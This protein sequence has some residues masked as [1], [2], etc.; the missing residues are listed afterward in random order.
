MSPRILLR[1]FLGR[2]SAEPW[3]SEGAE[4]AVPSGR[5]GRTGVFGAANRGGAGRDQ[6]A[7]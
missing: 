2:N 5:G 3:R 7:A 1:E 4:V 6:G